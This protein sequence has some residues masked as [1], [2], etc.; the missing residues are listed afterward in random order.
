MTHKE[1]RKHESDS[2]TSTADVDGKIHKSIPK[3]DMSRQLNDGQSPYLIGS[4]SAT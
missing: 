2:I 1:T 4:Q 3:Q